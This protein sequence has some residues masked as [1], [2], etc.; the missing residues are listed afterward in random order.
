M[1]ESLRVEPVTK[2][3]GTT[4]PIPLKNRIIKH[5]RLVIK[6]A[7][8]L[9]LIAAVIWSGNQYVQANMKDY[10]HV[11][12]NGDSIGTISDPAKVEQFKQ[13]KR[14]QLTKSD[15]DIQMVVKEPRLE[16]TP[17]RVFG[18]PA[19]D[20]AVLKQLERYFSAYPVGV[21]L[22]VDGK[23]V[24][25]VKDE[26][27]AKQVLEQ[28]K[29]NVIASL[30]QKKEPGK[31]GILSASSAG[32]APVTTELQKADFVQDV[33]MKQ[34]EIKPDQLMKPDELLN[35]LA[36]G[37]ARPTKYTVVDG[38]CVS[39]IAKKLNIPKQVIYQNNPWIYND[40][41]KV[42]EQLDLTVMNRHCPCGQ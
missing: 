12:A 5:K 22:L 16:F 30:Q 6:S 17:E 33:E 25:I 21:Q 10:Y 7:A 36:T 4:T 41:I 13:K 40:M 15:A 31:V 19:E 8:V 26:A 42:G 39:C 28:L 37:N 9:S 20:E 18:T 38:D 29:A 11:Y 32:D 2:E 34:L 35:K 24:G 27:T 23:P 14:E 3:Q 1:A